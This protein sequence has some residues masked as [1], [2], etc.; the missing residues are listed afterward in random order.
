MKRLRLSFAT[1]LLL[2]L[3][4][5][6]VIVLLVPSLRVSVGVRL[7]DQGILG[8]YEKTGLYRVR[9]LLTGALV[10]LIAG[11]LFSRTEFLKFGMNAAIQEWMAFLFRFKSIESLYFE[12]RKFTV[13][14]LSKARWTI[15]WRLPAW[16]Q[17]TEFRTAPFGPNY[18]PPNRR[19]LAF[20]RSRLDEMMKEAHLCLMREA[21]LH[22]SHPQTFWQLLTDEM[23]EVRFAW[24]KHQLADLSAHAKEHEPQCSALLLAFEQLTLAR[25][26]ERLGLPA[27]PCGKESAP[28]TFEVRVEQD[29]AFRMGKVI[30]L[31]GFEKGFGS[32]LSTAYTFCRSI[33]D[34][35]VAP[36]QTAV[37]IQLVGACQVMLLNVHQCPEPAALWAKALAH[38]MILLALNT[39]TLASAWQEIIQLAYQEDALLNLRHFDSP[40]NL[41]RGGSPILN[42]FLRDIPPYPTSWAVQLSCP[43]DN[44]FRQSVLADAWFAQMQELM[45]MFPNTNQ[46]AFSPAVSKD[47]FVRLWSVRRGYISFLNNEAS[48]AARMAHLDRKGAYCHWMRSIRK[49]SNATV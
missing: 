43:L 13:R 21:Y 25:C 30:T 14:W 49:G 1:L 18:L 37:V 38:A 32:A 28:M 5:G 31:P 33:K 20:L 44:L 34:P 8:A 4:L 46:D 47:D 22:D 7:W 39:M 12:A 9:F 24:E 42:L 48:T 15:L 19:Y 45:E 16:L 2:A 26:A 11:Y 36:G 23:L 10:G 27:L 29:I 6:V 35:S 41:S 40:Q 3:L 17:S